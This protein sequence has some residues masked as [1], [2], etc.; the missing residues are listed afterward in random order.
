MKKSL[1]FALTLFCSS[2][3][4]GAPD[5]ANLSQSQVE[6]VAREFSANFSHTGVSAPETDGLWGF[7][8]GV[9]AGKTTTPDLDDAGDVANLYHAG[10]VSRVH[11]PFEVFAEINLLPEQELSGLTIK[12]TSYEFGWN[13]GRSFGMPLDL[14]IGINFANSKFSFDQTSPTSTVEF[15]SNTR[16]MWV[17][18]SKSLLFITPYAKVGAASAETDIESTGSILS[19]QVSQKDTVD[20]SGSY[21]AFGANLQL[22]F[23]K[24]GLEASQI[25]S[26]SRVSGK[27]SFDF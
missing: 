7:E 24:L 27:L 3:F 5:F 14:A 11:L 21:F 18:I 6:D 1:I 23:L 13:A 9:V 10:L 8:L 16:I 25:M 19:Y 20:N 4:A 26:A 12:N 15:S 17:G 2:A 22:A